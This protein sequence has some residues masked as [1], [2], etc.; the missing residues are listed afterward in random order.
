MLLDNIGMEITEPGP[1]DFFARKAALLFPP[2]KKKGGRGRPSSADTTWPY[3]CLW[4]NPQPTGVPLAIVA[5][6][7]AQSVL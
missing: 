4:Q 1:F 3:F 5:V 2:H 6:P 7:S